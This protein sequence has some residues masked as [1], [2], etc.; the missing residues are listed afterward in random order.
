MKFTLSTGGVATC[1][2]PPAMIAV[3]QLG[4]TVAAAINQDV[5]TSPSD[6]GSQFRIDQNDCQ[7]VYNLGVNTFGAGSYRVDIMIDG[8]TVGSATFGLR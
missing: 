3:Y 5:F 4:G 2:L 8:S 6:T 7:Y 1:D